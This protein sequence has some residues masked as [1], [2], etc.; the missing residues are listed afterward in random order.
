MFWYSDEDVDVKG[1][2]QAWLNTQPAAEQQ[3]LSGW[4]EDY[5]YQALQWVLKHV[6]FNF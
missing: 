1:L 4:I 5:F 3:S 2:V 6:S